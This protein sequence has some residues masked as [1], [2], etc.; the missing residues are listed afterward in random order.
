MASTIDPALAKK[1]IKEYQQHNASANGPGL[2]TPDDQFLNGY[3]IDR[4]SLEALLSNPKVAGVSLHLAKHP[5]FAGKPSNKFTVL[6][7]GA[8]PNTAAGATTPYV[9]TGDVYSGP[10]PCPPWCTTV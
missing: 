7:A 2:K 9:N 10:P 4:E 1:L 6:Y 8:E 5:D 3:F